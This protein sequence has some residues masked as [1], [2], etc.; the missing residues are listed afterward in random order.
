MSYTVRLK[1]RTER[2]LDRLPIAVARRIWERLLA[3]ERDPRPRGAA[4]LEGVEGYRIRIGDYRVV[5]LVD[6]DQRVVDVAR[7]AHRR[8][9]YR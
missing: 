1:P 6:D 3:L 9:V 7:I 2:E 5:Y 4:K 8:E